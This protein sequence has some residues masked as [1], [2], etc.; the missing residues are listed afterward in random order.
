MSIYLP[1]PKNPNRFIEIMALPDEDTA[2]STWDCQYCGTVES[3]VKVECRNCGASK[4]RDALSERL[5]T[6]KKAG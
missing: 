4:P 1:D 5:Q 2:T 6:P 3:G